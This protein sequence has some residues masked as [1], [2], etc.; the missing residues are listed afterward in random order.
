MFLSSHFSPAPSPAL[1]PLP[2]LPFGRVASIGKGNVYHFRLSLR[3]RRRGYNEILDVNVNR[4]TNE[5]RLVSTLFYFPIF[6][7]FFVVVV[8]LGYA[9]YE[10]HVNFL[11]AAATEIHLPNGFY[12]GHALSRSNCVP[13]K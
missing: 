3:R 10:M 2:L 11:V 12:Y 7:V 4:T 8:V 13:R 6:L 5:R 1:P 9:L